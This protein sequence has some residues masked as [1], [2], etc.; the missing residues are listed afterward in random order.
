MIGVAI[1]A[2]SFA[3][4]AVTVARLKVRSK[5][6][7]AEDGNAWQQFTTGLNAPWRLEEANNFYNGGAKDISEKIVTLGAVPALGSAELTTKL[8]N[9]ELA[10]E[11]QVVEFCK[12]IAIYT[13][14][15]AIETYHVNVAEEQEVLITCGMN[16]CE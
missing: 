14:S 10:I 15:V 2:A 13:L 5:G 1:N 3:V 16:Q 6:S 9:A 4:A 8:G 12:W 7:G 11:S